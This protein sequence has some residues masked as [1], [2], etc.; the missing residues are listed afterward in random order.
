MPDESNEGLMARDQSHPDQGALDRPWDPTD[1]KAPVEGELVPDE[2]LEEFRAPN[3]DRSSEEAIDGELARQ[4]PQ[5]P[6]PSES[7]PAA[8]FAERNEHWEG[9]IHYQDARQPDPDHPAPAEDPFNRT[10]SEWQGVER[11]HTDSVDLEAERLSSQYQA[12]D[13]SRSQELS[14]SHEQSLER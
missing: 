7:N 4:R 14:M 11:T 10:S 13:W 2:A 9:V 3:L 12:G 8:P 6:T 1:T 5:F